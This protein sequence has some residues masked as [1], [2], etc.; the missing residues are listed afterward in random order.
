[1]RDPVLRLATELSERPRTPGRLL[2]WP[3]SA[4]PVEDSLRR[5]RLTIA[6][7]VAAATVVGLP[8]VAAAAPAFAGP[9]DVTVQLLAMNDFHG[10]I[11]DTTGS[12]SQL[13][14]S[15]GPDKVYGVNPK[16]GKS[17]DV[18]TTVGGAANVAAT[19]KS[20][21]SSFQQSTTGP[22][23]SFFVGAGDLISA[24]PFESSAY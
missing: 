19:V 9:K 21:Q 23:D 13:L 7:T 4:R 20:L 3:V 14:T 15:P 1:M 11:S 8:T 5:K 18:S 6:L 2:G 16:T 24:S 10:R 22:H 12:D 17:D